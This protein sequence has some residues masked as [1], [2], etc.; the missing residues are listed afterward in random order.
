MFISG[1]HKKSQ[2]ILIPISFSIVL[3]LTTFLLGI[4]QLQRL[5]WKNNLINNF[6]ILKNSEAIDISLIDKREFIKIKS[7]GIINRNKKIFFP[8]KTL[9]GQAGVRLAS[10]FISKNGE[11]YLIDEGWFSNKDLKY[12]KNNNDMFEVNI[13]GYTRFPI[14]EKFFTPKNNL[15]INE[16]YVYDLEEISEYLSSSLNRVLFIKK[17]NKNKENFLIASDYEHQFSNNHMQYAITWFSMS[18]AFLIMILVYL[19]KNKYE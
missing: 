14:K 4:W 8:A 11:I 7:K 5:N 9:N 2:S 19:K 13:I 17:L 10:E 6:N 12:F 15:Y 1:V 18:L 16:W 3:I